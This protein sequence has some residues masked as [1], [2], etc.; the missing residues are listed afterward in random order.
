M[1]EIIEFLAFL[2]LGETGENSGRRSSPAGIPHTHPLSGSPKPDGA[3][4]DYKPPQ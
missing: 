1:Y 4:S 3:F 2:Q